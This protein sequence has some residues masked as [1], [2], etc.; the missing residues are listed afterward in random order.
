MGDLNKDE[1]AQL[2]QIWLTGTVWAGD[3]ISKRAAH[4]LLY[5]G[6]VQCSDEGQWSIAENVTVRMEYDI[7]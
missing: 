3:L 4:T 1:Q 7:R 5:L 2:A 6:L